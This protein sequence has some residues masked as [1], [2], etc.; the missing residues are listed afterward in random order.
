MNTVTYILSS[1]HIDAVDC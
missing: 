1:T